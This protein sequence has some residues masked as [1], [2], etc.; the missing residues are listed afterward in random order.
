MNNLWWIRR[1]LRLDQNPALQAALAGAAGVI[2][3]FILDPH[4]LSQ[5]AAARQSFLFSGLQALAAELR[6]HGSRLVLRRGQPRAELARLLAESGAAAIY[7]AEDYSPYARRRDAAVASSLPL[8]LTGG[9][10]VH[11]PA[12]VHK[13]DG[14]PY[15]VFTPFSKAWKALPL[16]RFAPQPALTRLPPVPELVSEPI[17]AGTAPSGLPAGE[18]EAL[19]RLEAFLAGPVYTYGETRNRMDLEGTSAL[20]PYLRFGMLSPRQAAQQTVA[21]MF[22]APD[23]AARRSAETYLNE[24]IWR[25]FYTAIMY[26]FP[27]VLRQEFN[28]ALRQIAWRSAP[29]ELRAWQAGQ[30]GVPVV[31]AAMR[32]LAQTGWMHNR[33]RM[34]VASFLVK[35]LLIDWREGERWF[36]QHLVDGD[37]AANNGGWQWTAGTGTDAAPYF[38]IFN[39]LLQSARFDPDGAYIRRFVPE[40][41]AL[42]AEWIHTPW[43]M[44]AVLQETYRCHIGRDYPAPIVDL[45]LSR[46]RTLAA[47]KASRSA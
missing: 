33:A 22:A 45:S 2:P 19:R 27:S 43:L 10:T 35:N 13:A 28:P 7:A 15:T 40:L 39:P 8:R 1:D 12:A 21:A 6:A 41:A 20:S 30:T 36:M 18:R 11:P 37:P 46:E 31:D 25:E 42:P 44:P 3:V 26:Y 23:E 34:I 32:Q 47:Y 14:S 5:T 29:A 24:L 9:V 17:P 16:A 38:R 4:L